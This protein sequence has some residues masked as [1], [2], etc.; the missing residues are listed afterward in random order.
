[1]KKRY[2]NNNYLKIDKDI[3]YKVIVDY[4]KRFKPKTVLEVGC[5]NGNNIRTLDK[6]MKNVKFSGIDISDVGIHYAENHMHG[7]DFRV[8]DAKELPFEDNAFD[9]VFTVHALEQMKYTVRDACSEIYRVCKDTVVLFEPFFVMQNIFGK[10]H[11]IR[12]EYVQGIEF[13]IEDAGFKVKEFRLLYKEEMISR[14]S[15]NKT[16]V[17]VGVKVK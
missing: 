17:L 9:V 6:Y 11:N 4:I 10:W 7:G 8:C 3:E 1:L 15:I 14:G 5:G 16:G 13:Y 12:S 2:H